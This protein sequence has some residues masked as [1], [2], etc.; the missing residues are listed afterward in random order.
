MMQI[1][2]RQKENLPDGTVV[3]ADFGIIPTSISTVRDAFKLLK[4]PEPDSR[5]L[6]NFAL[7]SAAN[8]L[9]SDDGKKI[10]GPSNRLVLV[11]LKNPKGW[12]EHYSRARSHS[13]NWATSMV[14]EDQKIW[15]LNNISSFENCHYDF[16]VIGLRLHAY[17]R[18]FLESLSTNEQ[19]LLIALSKL[20]KN[21]SYEEIADEAWTDAKSASTLLG[22][23]VSKD[24]LSR[25]H[26]KTDKR[27]SNY[28][29]SDESVLFEIGFW[30]INQEPSEL[31]TQILSKR[32]SDWHASETIKRSSKFISEEGTFLNRFYTQEFL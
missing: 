13:R 10:S 15:F 17:V 11:E 8:L 7:G 30:F 18:A 12:N 21:S 22:R 9:V 2:Y 14:L 27:F 1:E 5:S 24:I 29:F 23:L 25:E 6:L 26:P 3:R 20:G 32:L 19:A 31:N 28:K 16:I 4:I